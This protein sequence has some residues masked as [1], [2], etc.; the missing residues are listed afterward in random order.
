ML[1]E[2]W[3]Y[4]ANSGVGLL[5]MHLYAEHR[6][7]YGLDYRLERV[8]KNKFRVVGGDHSNYIGYK[9][10]AL[11]HSGEFETTILLT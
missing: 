2:Q 3:G 6:V 1:C 9:Q 5:I 7:K 10:D 4:R 11:E 8:S